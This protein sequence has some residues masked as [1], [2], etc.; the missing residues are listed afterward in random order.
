MSISFV[1]AARS[2]DLFP[3]LRL[4]D[5]IHPYYNE[6]MEIIEDVI[7]K[8]PIVRSSHAMLTLHGAAELAPVGPCIN[9]AGQ[10]KRV[11]LTLQRASA[12]PCRC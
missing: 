10:D 12:R 8:L 5:D 2:T 7:S 1:I 9:G 4:I 11:A 6:S 3:G